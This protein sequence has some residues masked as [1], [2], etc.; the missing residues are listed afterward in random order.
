MPG[1]ALKVEHI[2]EEEIMHN[3]RTEYIFGQLDNFPCLRRRQQLW[4]DPRFNNAVEQ[5]VHRLV[6]FVIRVP[7]NDVLDQCLRNA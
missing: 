1:E 4:A 7:G 3:I 2:I 6:R 5:F